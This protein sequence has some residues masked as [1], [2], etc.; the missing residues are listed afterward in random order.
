MHEALNNVTVEDWASRVAHVERKME[1]NFHK[2]VARD[3]VVQNLTINLRQS[4]SDSSVD[5]VIME[6]EG[7]EE[8]EEEEVLA[9]PLKLV[10]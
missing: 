9:T 4:D 2:E 3:S 8:K 10:Q 7:E 5:K 1:E 6:E